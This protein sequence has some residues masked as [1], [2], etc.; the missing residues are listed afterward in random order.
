MQFPLG[1]GQ[2][3]AIERPDRDADLR[4]DLSVFG[5]HG[6]TVAEGFKSAQRVGPRVG[7]NAGGTGLSGEMKDT[8]AGNMDQTAKAG[9]ITTSSQP[10]Y[11]SAPN[12]L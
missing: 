7:D 2:D 5:F 1:L 4:P 6:M 11:N 12:A 8:M 10:T 3:R 9:A